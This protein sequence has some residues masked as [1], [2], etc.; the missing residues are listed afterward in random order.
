MK[1]C[2]Q[3]KTNRRF[4]KIYLQTS[5][6]SLLHAGFFLDLFSDTENEGDMIPRNVSLLP[7]DYMAIFP[8]RQDIPGYRVQTSASIPEISRGFLYSLQAMTELGACLKLRGDRFLPLPSNL[9]FINT[10]IIQC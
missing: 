5:T 1:S 7:T 2:S 4:G 8:R 9:L 3:L 10:P 6:C